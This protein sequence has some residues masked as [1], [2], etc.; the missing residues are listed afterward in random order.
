MKNAILILFASFIFSGMAAQDEETIAISKDACNCMQDIDLTI[1]K[2]AQYDSIKSCISSA[3]F[4]YQFKKALEKIPKEVKDTTNKT[5]EILKGLSQDS[6]KQINIEIVTDKN[7][8]IIEGYSLRN[9]PAMKKIMASDNSQ[10]SN[11]VSNKKK[12]IDFYNKGQ[13][14]YAQGNYGNAIVEFSKAVKKD[15][16]FAFA[17]DNLGLSYRKQGQLKQAIDCYNK[18]LD[19][20]PNGKVPLMNKPIAYAMLKDYK[21]AIKSYKNMIAVYP[22]DAEG[23]YGI[24]RIYHLKGDYENAV[25]NMMKAYKMYGE[26][27]SPYIRDA[28]TNLA[29][30]YKELKAKNQLEIFNKLSEKYNIKIKE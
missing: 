3:I 2:E 30:F 28:E 13:K 1:K 4:S 6:S 12:A 22:N 27:N 23:Y 18:S 17:W 9:C 11:S 14:Y 7:Y 15:K 24:G 10:S 16:N 25:E 5:P 21:N 8:N 20:D 19:I 26:A 29:M